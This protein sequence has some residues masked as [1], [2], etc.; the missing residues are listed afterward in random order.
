MTGD[1]LVRLVKR[2]LI[3]GGGQAFCCKEGGR[4]WY[5]LVALVEKLLSGGREE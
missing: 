2:G 5:M 3:Q 4:T 1:Q